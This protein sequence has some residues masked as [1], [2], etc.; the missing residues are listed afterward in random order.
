[1]TTG[2]IVLRDGVP[3]RYEDGFDEANPEARALLLSE[4]ATVFP[5]PDAAREVMHSTWRYARAHGY[6]WGQDQP[7]AWVLVPLHATT[8]P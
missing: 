2:F 7:E 1:M 8:R 3:C 5:T 6:D 4:A